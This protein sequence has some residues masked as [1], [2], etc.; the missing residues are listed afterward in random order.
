MTTKKFSGA[1][2]NVDEKYVAEATT[3]TAKRSKHKW[4]RW[5]AIAACLSLIVAGGML[6][7]L[8]HPSDL[9]SNSVASYFVIT[10]YA[11]EG[12]LS[13]LE[14]SEGFFNSTVSQENVFGVD[15]PLFEFSVRPSDLKGN[16]A[17]YSRFDISISYNGVDVNGMDDHIMVGYLIPMPNSDG[18]WAYSISGWFTEP[19]DIIVS[20]MDKESRQIVE[21]ITVRV[22]Y[23]EDRQ[24][25]E[26]TITNLNTLY[27]KQKQAVEANESLMQYFYDQGY[28]TDY[29]DYFGGC[30]IEDD[31][32]YVRLVNPSD[33]D[34]TA[35][36]R[37]LDRYADVVVYENGEM[38]MADL[39]AYADETVDELIELGY[40]VTSWYVDSITGNV[41]I[42][43]LEEDLSAVTEWI[44]DRNDQHSGFKV[45]V[46]KGDYITLD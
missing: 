34:V 30:Y 15:M 6:G 45:I 28:V 37:V 4:V 38:S 42:Q 43:V 19:T 5:V 7:N 36:S 13:E 1:L 35:L 23:L 46:E 12:E 40:K 16:E 2:G 11:A 27:A 9:P 29:P 39:Q 33:E 22:T 10:A 26:L 31:K 18:E 3:Y 25:Y 41:V 24:E 20:I 14:L 8:F 17:L 44:A 21:T 32:L